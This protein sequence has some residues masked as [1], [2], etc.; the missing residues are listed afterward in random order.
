M[1]LVS[2]P[3]SVGAVQ[4]AYMHLAACLSSQGN[5]STCHAINSRVCYTALEGMCHPTESLA[6]INRYVF[7]THAGSGVAM[8]YQQ[9]AAEEQQK[10]SGAAAAHSVKE[11]KVS[12]ASRGFAATGANKQ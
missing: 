6:V 11:P 10:V 8:M 1:E 5:A 4:L 12:L 2:G 3:S 7:N 9:M